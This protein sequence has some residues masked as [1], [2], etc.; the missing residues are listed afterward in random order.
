MAS[1]RA[2]R[3]P[4]QPRHTRGP[5]G[6]FSTREGPP[7]RSLTFAEVQRY[8]VG[9]LKPGTNYAAAFPS[10]SRP[11]AR[12]FRRSG[13]VRPGEARRRGSCALQ[14]R[15]QAHAD[16]RRR[17]AGPRDLRGGCRQGGARGRPRR[18][19]VS[20]Q[21]STGA[22]SACSASRRRS[23]ACASPPRAQLR[24]HPAR[25]ARPLAVACRARRRR[26]R[27][28]GA[29]LGGGRRLRGLV[30][31]FRNVKADDCGRQSA[32][33]EGHPLDRERPRRHGAPDRARRRRHHHRLSGPP[34]RCD[35][36][37]EHAAAAAGEHADP[38]F[39]WPAARLAT[40][41]ASIREEAT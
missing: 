6:H 40:L 2:A 13:A 1:G 20:V 3:P 30:A 7:I 15:D 34:A 16:L 39:A 19:R 4:P 31:A 10:S 12:A 8:D 41:P 17:D 25:Q 37:E 21:S 18:T 35:G 26:L 32:Q 24:H 29:A 33:P 38:P 36:G 22:R 5:D 28:L 11:T 9:R 27:R 14:H 23:S